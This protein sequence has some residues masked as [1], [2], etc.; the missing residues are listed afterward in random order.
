MVKLN[1]TV[2]STNKTDVYHNR[3]GDQQIANLEK[4]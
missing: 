2:I 4:W 3:H 1:F